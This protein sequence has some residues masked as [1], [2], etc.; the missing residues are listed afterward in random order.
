VPSLATQCWPLRQGR[1]ISS[2][3]S[4]QLT[5]ASP[6]WLQLVLP[7]SHSTLPVHVPALHC[8]PLSQSSLLLQAA[9][10]GATSI[11][12]E[13]SAPSPQPDAPKTNTPNASQLSNRAANRRAQLFD[14]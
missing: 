8:W 2:P 7:G 10:P 14:G 13:L 5:T 4:L 11:V 12:L 3:V 9:W 6:S 1:T